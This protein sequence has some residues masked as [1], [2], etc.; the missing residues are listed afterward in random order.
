MSKP[1]KRYDTYV[2]TLVSGFLSGDIEK[3]E[4]GEGLLRLAK[5]IMPFHKDVQSFSIVKNYAGVL[6]RA[7]M[8]GLEFTRRQDWF[9]RPEVR[10]GVALAVLDTL[11]EHVTLDLIDVAFADTVKARKLIEDWRMF[12]GIWHF[13]PNFKNGLR[14]LSKNM[15]FTSRFIDT[16]RTAG[17]T[18]VI[19]HHYIEDQGLTVDELLTSK[20]C[21]RD[22]YIQWCQMW[23]S[24]LLDYN[25]SYVIFG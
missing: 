9:L 25:K 2:S 19:L 3:P 24:V 18:T 23:R 1:S 15:E 21:M 14:V 4:L 13:I 16:K 10:R 22:I 11:E 6:S 5:S 8:E 20:D 12:Y 7:E 17:L